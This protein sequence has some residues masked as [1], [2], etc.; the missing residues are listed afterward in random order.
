ML[1][2]QSVVF[3]THFCHDWLHDSILLCS[4]SHSRSPA[5]SLQHPLSD[6]GIIECWNLATNNDT[7]GMGMG[8]AR[9]GTGRNAGLLLLL[10]LGAAT[11]L[12]S[13]RSPGLEI[14]RGTFPSVCAQYRLHLSL[15]C[16]SGEE[17]L[18][19]SWAGYRQPSSLLRCALQVVYFSQVGY[20]STQGA[21]DQLKFELHFRRLF[22]KVD[23]LGVDFLQRERVGELGGFAA[24]FA[25]ASSIDPKASRVLELGERLEVVF[26]AC[27]PTLAHHG[28]RS[29]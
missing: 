2:S 27:L 17:G 7:H 14:S 6:I 9:M 21:T 5:H 8:I 11:V 10:M 25:T 12:E 22:D 4:Q 15:G 18:P 3:G 20:G 29:V 19:Q 28:K 24:F 26:K 16:K 23:Y 1:V 13:G